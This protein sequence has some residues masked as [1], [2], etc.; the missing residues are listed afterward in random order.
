MSSGEF[1]EWHEYYG[2]EPFAADRNEL[3]MALL[4]SSLAM[5]KS[6]LDDFIISN[7]NKTKQKR[8]ISM[9]TAAEINKLAGV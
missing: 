7:K 3:Q 4:S 2:I 6:K 8:G 1:L 9:A 5:G